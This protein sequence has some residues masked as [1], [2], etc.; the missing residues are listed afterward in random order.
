MMTFKQLEAIY[1]VA[2]LGGFSAAAERLHT[3]Q[4]AISRRIQELEAAFDTPLFDRSQRTARLTEKG[5][6]MVLLAGQM[7]AQRDA[8]TEA[9]SRPGVVQRRI[10]IGVTELTSMTWLPRL[11]RLIQ[12][13]YPKVVIEPDVDLSLSLR[14]KLLASEVDLIV[15]PDAF[16]DSRFVA[17]PVGRV[18]SAWMC[19]PGLMDASRPVALPDLAAQ[20]LLV[21]GDRSGTGVVYGRWF[22][23]QGITLRDTLVSNNMIALIGMAVAGLGVSYLPWR[24]LSPLIADGSLAVLRVAPELPEVTYMAMHRD[25]AGGSLVAAVA[26]LAQQC[27][28]FS[29]LFQTGEGDA[30]HALAG[31]SA[32]AA[33]IQLS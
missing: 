23:A 1:W 5:E 16:Q 14:D 18:A 21:Q 2:R 13:Q 17:Q 9:F 33:A 24:C 4:S 7:L 8:A 12:A 30:S 25:E 31:G 10:R 15:V 29:R 20:R 19:K 22:Q 3:T 28:D 11:V 27:C 6:E 32:L 26:A